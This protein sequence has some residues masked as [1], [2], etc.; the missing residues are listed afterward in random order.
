[1]RINPNSFRRLATTFLFELEFIQAPSAFEG[2]GNSYVLAMLQNA[3]AALGLEKPPFQILKD[4]EIFDWYYEKVQALWGLDQKQLSPKKAFYES[5]EWLDLRYR[6]LKM[7]GGC[8]QCCGNRPSEGN[9][10]HVDHIKPRSKYP[11]L[12]LEL[13]NLQVLCKACNFGKRAW[14]ETDWRNAA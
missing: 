4:E 12:E 13:S 2:H 11:Y 1:M 7:H 14:D 9:P 10:L 8:C 3:F 6:A 5:D